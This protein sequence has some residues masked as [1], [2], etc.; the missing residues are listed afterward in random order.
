MKK[1]FKGIGHQLIVRYS[2]LFVVFTVMFVVT[3]TLIARSALIKN[4]SVLLSNFAKQIGNDI[5]RVI[6]LEISKVEM[7]AETPIL[8]DANTPQDVKFEY[9]KKIVDTQG[10]K[11]AALIDLDGN[12]K[13]ILGESV[14]VKD[15][16]YFKANLEGKSYF[17]PPNVSKADGGLQ[18]SI[19]SPIKS[20]D[21]IV[22]IVFFS[23]DA[24]K[25]SEITNS[26]KFGET[27]SAY[28]IDQ[29]GTNIINNDIEKVKNKVNRIEDAKK[30]SKYQ[31]LADIT[32]KMISGENGTG[33]YHLNGDKK[34][35]GYAPIESTGWSVGVTSEVKDMLSGLAALIVDMVSIGIIT[36]V[37]LILLTYLISKKIAVRLKK[38]KVEMN[39]IAEGDFRESE[40]TDIVSD[41]IGDI[42]VS[43]N[44]TKK[45]VAGALKQIQDSA[46]NII[47]EEKELKSISDRFI[48]GTKNIN[49][50]IQQFTKATETQTNELSSINDIM[51][52]FG[53]V[54][55]EN[56]K[57]VVN[58][59]TK[60]G[61][62]SEKVTGSC[63]DMTKISESMSELSENFAMFAKEIAEMKDEM[64]T[65]NDITKFINGISDQTNLL[66]LNAAIEAARAGEAGKGFSV[67]AEEIRKLAE[68]SK[69]S[70]K[71]IYNV[72]SSVVGKT[73]TI[74]SRSNGINDSLQDGTA[75]VNNSLTAFEKILSDISEITPM[76]QEIT[77]NFD[78]I[79]DDKDKIMKK[80]EEVSAVSEE[81][82]ANAEEI[83]AST[84]EFVSST[85]IMEEAN[86]HLLKLT[87][88]MQE[89]V[90]R[91]T[92]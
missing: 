44:E 58:I 13:T 16:E 90:G 25:F 5:D 32:K 24:E 75:N 54:I 55:N 92:I 23:K 68:Q 41:E 29:N 57:Y 34:F 3:G 18:I 37:V 47:D 19:T 20:G 89:A 61:S 84:S 14:N 65:I 35:V 50:S 59:N 1:K 22:G 28:V 33:T 7:V 91:F 8:Q 76:I 38:L 45:A 51:V 69:E 12:C 73:E 56:N 48:D 77:T 78:G 36:N 52:D 4:S 60:A 2:S 86:E 71:N 15:K 87:D 39:A 82:V 49:D 80:I 64:H 88:K 83:S 70:T 40:I 72:I 81:I 62:I 42:Y 66:A 53:D 10:Y 31:E 11:K 6:N 17:T 43:L 9:L 85:E 46:N 74:V 67:V 30:D 63:E 27:G 79:I 21:K 26:I